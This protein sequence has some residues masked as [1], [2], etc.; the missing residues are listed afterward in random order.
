[1]ATFDLY[2]LE[3][4]LLP[5]CRLAFRQLFVNYSGDRFYGMGLWTE[6]GLGWLLPTAMSEEGHDELLRQC[7]VKGWYAD[8]TDEEIRLLARW[9]PEDSRHNAEGRSY[10]DDVNVIMAEIADVLLDIDIDQ[11]WEEFETFY[12]QVIRVICNVFIVLG[13]EGMFG[14]GEAR[15]AV[16]VTLMT[17]DQDESILEIGRRVN[18][19]GSV[20]RFSMEWTQ[21]K[22]LIQSLTSRRQV[23]RQGKKPKPLLRQA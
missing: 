9:S 10:F 3:S 11:G 20:Q 5:A 21:R 19:V 12:A 1:M 8:E 16:F 22:E 4:A 14:A 7:R 15:E 6:G 2:R 13:D 17:M 23:S 18:P